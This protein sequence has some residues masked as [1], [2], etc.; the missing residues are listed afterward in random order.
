MLGCPS[1]LTSHHPNILT[2][3]ADMDLNPAVELSSFG[4]VVGTLR[5]RLAETNR[6]NA[7]WRDALLHEVVANTVRAPLGKTLVVLRRADVV[8]VTFDGNG[9]VGV[10]LEVAREIAECLARLS[11]ERGRVEVK[12]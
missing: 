2:G 12:Q 5:L 9:L 8:G 10:S 6:G 3:S 1:G 7:R 4:R 11:T